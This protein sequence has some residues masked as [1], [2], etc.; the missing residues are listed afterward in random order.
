MINTVRDKK[1][2]EDIDWIVEMREK[3]NNT[4]DNRRGK[5]KYSYVEM[6]PKDERNKKW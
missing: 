1:R 6:V 2:R 3:N 5:E 4:E